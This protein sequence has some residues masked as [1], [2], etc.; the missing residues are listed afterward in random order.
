[1]QLFPDKLKRVG[2]AF[3]VTNVLFNKDHNDKN[4]AVYKEAKSSFESKVR[5][6]V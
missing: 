5:M 1:M 6:W 4:S 3:K 2:G